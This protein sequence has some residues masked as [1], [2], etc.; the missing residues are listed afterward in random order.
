MSLQVL[1]LDPAAEF[2]ASTTS[3]EEQSPEEEQAGASGQTSVEEL[4]EE[5]RLGF[6][7]LL[8]EAERVWRIEAG[9][10][11]TK[12]ASNL[13]KICLFISFHSL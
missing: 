11:Y 6:Q 3:A 12:Q 10:K 7:E 1:G 5:D 4:S 2:V 9:N 13:D 8:E